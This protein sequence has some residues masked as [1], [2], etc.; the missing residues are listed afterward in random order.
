MGQV[1]SLVLGHFVGGERTIRKNWPRRFGPIPPPVKVAGDLAFDGLR[2][3]YW[4]CLLRILDLFS[5]PPR[6]GMVVPFHLRSNCT[7]AVSDLLPLARDPSG[8]F[9]PHDLYLQV[10]AVCIATADSSYTPREDL[11]WLLFPPITNHTCLGEFVSEP[12]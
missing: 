8:S 6:S 1:G 10:F 5:Q 12:G 7:P 4:M 2:K 3:F 11:G 9:W